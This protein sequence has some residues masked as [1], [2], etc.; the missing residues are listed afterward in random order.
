M[1]AGN[2]HTH[3]SVE[4]A[5]LTPA[6]HRKRCY[7]RQQNMAPFLKTEL[8]RT[9]EITL[10]TTATG[11]GSHLRSNPDYHHG[12]KSLAVAGFCFLT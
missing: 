12:L 6:C 10:T 3:N 8:N 11:T 4:T 5:T 7:T 9:G 2:G 1:I